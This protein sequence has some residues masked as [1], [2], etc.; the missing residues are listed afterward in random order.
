M[1]DLY[2]GG[3]SIRIQA[4][5]GCGKTSILR[6]IA[7]SSS[8]PVTYLAYNTEIANESRLSFPGN[9][10]CATT[11]G[12]ARR[13]LPPTLKSKAGRGHN[14]TL[15]MVRRFLTSRH[16]IGEEIA[17]GVSYVV[18]KA[19]EAF[20]NTADAEITLEHV[21]S[22]GALLWCDVNPHEIV[23][24]VKL[25]WSSVIHPDGE[26]PLFHDA[27]LKY[28]YLGGIKF[29]CDL[30][31]VDE[32]QDL[33]PLTLALID[34]AKCQLILVGDRHQEL[35]GW[36]GACE[37]MDV[38]QTE[39]DASLTLCF[40]LGE[41][42]TNIANRLLEGLGEERLRPNP[43]ITT[44]AAT[45]HQRVRL[46]RSNTTLFVNTVERASHHKRV[47]ILGG[48]G[49]LHS[50]VDDV[51]RLQ[52]GRMVYG[53]VFSGFRDWRDTKSQVLGS[54]G[55]SLKG[56][57]KMADELGV[58]RM[59]NGLNKLPEIEDKADI[60][61]GTVH[62]SKGREW[63]SV[64]VYHDFKGDEATALAGYFLIPKE[65]MRLVY[66][67]VTRASKTIFLE[68]QLARRFD[69]DQFL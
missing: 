6:E 15:Q 51:E 4:L 39:K 11:H 26:L 63:D 5:A 48:T 66:V 10:T 58:T 12:L 35:Y 44:K 55:S 7:R 43:K 14:I 46:V 57:V 52:S 27:Y 3:Y 69:L 65:Q 40:R 33:N 54:R 53:G 13:Q 8:R 47:H 60:V 29:D 62:S 28:V 38:I 67:A 17:A 19:L 30:L 50:L 56:F 23:P 9:A 59:R 32:V 36:R 24:L 20:C 41:L 1:L 45:R 31:L 42:G 25:A 34:T 61:M 49:Q 2:R 22:A 37:S 16:N 68:K 64:S 18:F 21:A